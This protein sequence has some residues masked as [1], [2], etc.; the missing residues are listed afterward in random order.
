MSSLERLWQDLSSAAL[1]GALRRPL[2]AGALAGLPG[3]LQQALQP[4]PGEDGEGLLLRAAA[5]VAVHRRAGQLPPLGQ[6]AWLTPAPADDWPRCSR[7]A[8]A[9]LERILAAG[10]AALL[11]EWIG[12][13]AAKR[14][15][16]REEQLPALLQQQKAIL[17]LRAELL[18]ALGERGRWLA[19]LN[20]DWS[21]FRWFQDERAWR[22]G[23]RKER[24]ACLD[25]LRASDPGQACALL[26]S[27]WAEESPADRQAFLQ[28]LANGLSMAD[29]P[30]LESTLDD[31][32][33]DVRQ[34]AAAL[35]A[36][37]PQARL[38]QRMA[39]RAR[40]LLVWKNRLLRGVLEARLPERCEA[41]MLRDGIA[42]KPPADSPLGERAWWLAQII[43]AV[44]PGA[45]TGAWNRRPPALLE[46]AAK[47]EWCDALLYGW[48]EAA[49]RH[50]D[51]DWLD[52][53]FVFE[54]RRADPR[55]AFELFSRLPEASRDREMAALLRGGPSL[56]YDQPASIWLLACRF[57]WSKPL[58]Q[59]V[60]RSICQ[61]LQQ[62]D[63]QPWR[64]EIL[65]RE[66]GAYFH[67]EML[68]QAIQQVQAAQ[69]KRE[70]A[71]PYARDLLSIL[72]F[73]L[74]MRRSFDET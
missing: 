68:E 16:V 69:Q 63:F 33:A 36:R 52:A 23:T 58:T 59:A 61:T 67:P 46:A 22:E 72:Q 37:L 19:A 9:C 64:W 26:E 34:A 31:R 56:S 20:P 3:R 13:A 30:F 73:R 62:N 32:R 24:L 10:Q 45:W 66:I 65:L 8:G 71:D 40:R 28:A 39:G 51:A 43:A 60:A 41:D 74:D 14:R 11:R 5:L 1:L 17:P 2:R 15:R 48:T 18:P 57:P 12:L 7:R 47:T 4:R 29:E 53:L 27:S 42:P 38:V 50:A 25:D 44:P 35:L 55:R 49:L 21:A 54:T 6:P 70:K